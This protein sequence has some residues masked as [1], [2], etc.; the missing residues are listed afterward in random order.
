[1]TKNPQPNAG[2]VTEKQIQ[3][4]VANLPEAINT[5]HGGYVLIVMGNMRQGKDGE[6]QEGCRCIGSYDFTGVEVSQCMNI[7][8][9]ATAHVLRGSMAWLDSYPPEARMKLAEMLMEAVTKML[10]ASQGEGLLARFMEDLKG[11]KPDDQRKQA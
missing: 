5:G 10:V 8:A 6:M 4:L 1:M 11:G 3:E 9:S 7:L 2:K